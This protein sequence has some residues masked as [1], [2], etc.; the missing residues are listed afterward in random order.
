[1]SAL[2]L[3]GLALALLAGGTWLI[4]RRRGFA[5]LSTP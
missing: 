5:S 1:M 2:G 3:A 4:S